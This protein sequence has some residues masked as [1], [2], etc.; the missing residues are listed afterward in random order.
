MFLEAQAMA[1][2]DR[3]RFEAVV[4]P[5][6]SDDAAFE[7]AHRFA[8][9]RGWLENLV[10]IIIDEGLEDGSLTR[11]LAEDRANS[12]DAELQAMTNL[13]S[14][15]EQPDVI[16]RGIGNGMRWTGKILINGKAEGTGILIGP[17]L[18][19]T[20]WHVVRGLFTPTANGDWH[21]DP[22][23]YTE[24]QIEFDDFLAK[25]GRTLRPS[26]TLRV[27]AHQNWCVCFSACHKDEIDGKLPDN[28]AQLDGFW[29]YT[30]IRL[31]KAPGL[32]R[33]WASLD[34]RSIVP[35]V[36][37]SIILFQHPAGQPLK[38]DRN[39][40]AAMDPPAPSVI[41]KFRF[42]HRA[43]SLGGSSG[44]PCFDKSFMLFGFHQGVWR[45]AP[46]NGGVTTNRGVPA[47]RILKHITDS[48]KELPALDPSENP[49]WSLGVKNAYAPVIGTEDFQ[50]IIWRSAVAGKPKLLVITGADDVGKTFRVNLLSIMLSEGGH[51][52]ITLNAKSIS[53][54][55]AR[56]LAE[57]IC[58]EAGAD[59]PDFTP[60]SDINSTSSVWLK[61]EVLVKIMS[62]LDAA[63]KGRL[64][65]L[66]ITDLNAFKIV[67]EDASE[68]LFLLYGQ[69][70]SVDW[71]RVVLDGMNG[72]IPS[73]LNEDTEWHRVSEIKRSDIET[74]F[75]RFLTELD[76]PIDPTVL[77]VHT[78]MSFD[79]YHQ[80]LNRDPNAAMSRLD[81]EVRSVANAY[82]RAG[83]QN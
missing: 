53:N 11:E 32:M 14:G 39:F 43:N 66:S 56:T 41:P 13:A 79:K 28:L 22:T 21:P 73:A 7:L 80:T 72:D 76:M 30:I 40:I 34:A 9:A 18:L 15:F 82:L 31:E 52:K 61:D 65:W 8:Q 47:V 49:I 60:A 83:N 1:N 51:L 26:A 71:L 75:K 20:A 63:R 23:G 10:N 46:Q 50:K 42:L 68:L 59:V 54:L 62:A 3:V 81:E 70:L 27:G 33:R 25:I 12:G 55:D 64:V 4:D 78:N 44:G 77:S 29:D 19:I 35:R 38:M 17:N 74:Y 16:Y 48:I 67:N 36:D 2:V 57:R 24:L 58:V 6:M 45:T 69:I 37:E 5:S